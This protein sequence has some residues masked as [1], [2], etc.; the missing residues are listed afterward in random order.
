MML[1]SPALMG[2]ARDTGVALLDRLKIRVQRFPI[3]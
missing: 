2:R 3:D 1:A